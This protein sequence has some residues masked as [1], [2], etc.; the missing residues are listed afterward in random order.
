MRKYK[1]R[2]RHE[3]GVWL[4]G[5]LMSINDLTCIFQVG[6]NPFENENFPYDNVVDP[7][8]VGQHTGLKDKNGEEIYEGDIV[9]AVA[10]Y[11]NKPLQVTFM[12]GAFCLTNPNCCDTCS[13]REGCVSTLMEAIH[14]LGVIG[15]IHEHPEIFGS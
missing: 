8:T 9:R 12:S 2:G 1:F 10:A 11:S 6:V 14:P 13:N 4:L 15:N 5:E 3:D 7:E